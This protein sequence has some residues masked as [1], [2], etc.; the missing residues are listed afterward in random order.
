[1]TDNQYEQIGLLLKSLGDIFSHKISPNIEQRLWYF[2]NI[3]FNVKL[4]WPLF[5][6]TLLK[7]GPLL[8]LAS[9]HTVHN[10]LKADSHKQCLMRVAA[11]DSCISTK[12]ENFLFFST[13]HFCHSRTCQ[14]KIE[15]F[16]FFSTAHFCHSRTCQTK[17]VCESAVNLG[18]TLTV[19]NNL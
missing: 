5:W 12:I 13:A 8:I 19:T 6:A 14:T 17:L 3:S 10:C 7:I 9:G 2:K 11:A 4:L 1:M 15:K 16:L 18:Y